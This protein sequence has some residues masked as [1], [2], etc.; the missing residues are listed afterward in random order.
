MLKTVR[1]ATVLTVGNALH[2]PAADSFRATL[3]EIVDRD[4][5]TDLLVQRQGVTRSNRS[6][7]LVSQP[8]GESRD[9]AM[10]ALFEVIVLRDSSGRAAHLRR[11]FDPRRL[12]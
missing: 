7:F 3:I 6:R 12:R 2:Q 11:M 5:R 8:D 9:A 1:L 4:I 10:T